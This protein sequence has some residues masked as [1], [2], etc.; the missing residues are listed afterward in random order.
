MKNKKRLA[1]IVIII[2]IIITLIPLFFWIRYTYKID[3]TQERW[4]SY[5]DEN[6]YHMVKSLEDD[7]ELNGMS[8]KEIVQLLGTPSTEYEDSYEY[9]IRD[10]VI[11]GWKVLVICFE[12]DKVKDVYE[13]IE[14]W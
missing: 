7:Y 5:S 2:L 11:A 1:I 10:D 3:F 13:G 9:R 14:D 8:R 6:K 4:E 12:D